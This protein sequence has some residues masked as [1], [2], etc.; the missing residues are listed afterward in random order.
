MLKFITKLG[1]SAAL[2]L[3]WAVV[4]LCI[5]VQDFIEDAKYG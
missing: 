5:A 4:G 2:L 1:L 3:V